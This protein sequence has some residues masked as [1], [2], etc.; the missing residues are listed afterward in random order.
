MVPR[1]DGRIQGTIVKRA[2]DNNG[3]PIG[4][5]NPNIYLDTRKY[6]VELSDG[7]VEEYY[8]NVI[9]E[10]L[11]SQVDS[12]GRQYVLM[13]EISDHQKDGTAVPISDGWIKMKNG[14]RTR[15]KTTQGWK[16]LVEW[17]EGGSDWIALKDLKESYP[18][19]VAEYA[20][21]N[22]I[23]KEPAFAW[24]VNEVLRRR[25]RIISKVKSRYW[26]TTHKFGLE[27]P[28]SVEEAFR[29]NQ[30]NGNHFWREVI[31]K[32]MQKIKGMGAFERYDKATPTELKNGER[33]VRRY[34]QNGCHMIF[35]VKMDGLFTRK[36]RFVANGN[37]TKDVASSHTYASVVT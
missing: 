31:E 13:K 5:R 8:A 10:N 28:H 32:E 36:A 24:W 21:A 22:K 14:R 20:K 2:K 30:R 23:D 27:L 35:D 37:E 26:K 4:K 6:E 34:Q 16:L 1:P 33:K 3:N 19:E 17:K 29:I 25:N 11:F 15:R 7:T 18:V 9:A 12:E